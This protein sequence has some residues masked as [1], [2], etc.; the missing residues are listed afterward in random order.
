MTSPNHTLPPALQATIEQLETEAGTLRYYVDPGPT[1]AGGHRDLVLLHSINAAPSAMEMKPL[2]EYYRQHRRLLAP[3]LPGFGLSERPDIDYSPQLYADA[4]TAWLEH[5]T[6]EPVDV[7]ALSTTAE[8]AARAALAAPSR[9]ASLTLISPTGLGERQPPGAPT[10]Q[11]LLSFFRLPGVGSSL[12]RLL[13]S[14]TSIRYFLNMAFHGE[15]PKELMDYARATTRQPGA[16][17]APYCF[18]STKL[19]TDRA[20]ETLYAK[21]AMPTLVLYDQDPNVG[22]DRLPALLERNAIIQAERITPTLGMPHWEQPE[23]TRAA[24]EKF[25]ELVETGAS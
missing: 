22:F 3:D 1:Q 21:L 18:L 24:L 19:F 13:S 10:Q 15:T 16:R 11:R 17:F 20:W 7:V 9:F 5:A 23:K 12:Y 14:R 4:I 8:F 25:W 2:F 6:T